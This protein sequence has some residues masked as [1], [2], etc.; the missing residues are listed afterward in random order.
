ML[1]LLQE[2]PERAEDFADSSTSTVLGMMET[3]ETR[4]VVSPKMRRALANIERGAERW[5]AGER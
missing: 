4:S 1:E 2:L 3:A 5:K